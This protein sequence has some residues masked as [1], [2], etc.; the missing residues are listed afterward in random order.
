MAAPTCACRELGRFEPS[1]RRWLSG[2]A[3]TVESSEQGATRHVS[4]SYFLYP[5]QRDSWSIEEELYISDRKVTWSS[6]SRPVKNFSFEAPVLQAVWC[7]FQGGRMEDEMMDRQSNTLDQLP[8]NVYLCVL[9]KNELAVHSSDGEEYT[10]SLPFHAT[11]MWETSA[12][13]LLI[14]AE[15]ENANGPR[16]F[17]LLHPLAE[18]KPVGILQDGKLDILRLSSSKVP[19]LATMV[20]KVF[21]CEQVF[22][23]DEAF[24]PVLMTF[25][26][27]S[28][29]RVIWAVSRLP[30]KQWTPATT[31]LACSSSGGISYEEGD[32][33]AMVY[34]HQFGWTACGSIGLGAEIRKDWRPSHCEVVV[35]PVWRAAGSVESKT[36]IIYSQSND[37]MFL[38]LLQPDDR[39]AVYSVTFRDE[40]AQDFK[41]S[42]HNPSG[43]KPPDHNPRNLKLSDH[44]LQFKSRLAESKFVPKKIINSVAQVTS[45]EAMWGISISDSTSVEKAALALVISNQNELILYQ[46]L[47]PL[48][49]LRLRA[50]SSKYTRLSN[51]VCGRVNV[52]T[53]DGQCFRF[54]VPYASCSLSRSVLV[55]IRNNMSD[56]FYLY[57]RRCMLALEWGVVDGESCRDGPGGEWGYLAGVLQALIE[58][59]KI[60]RHFDA[61]DDFD[62]MFPTNSM[63]TSSSWEL[64]LQSEFHLQQHKGGSLP[65]LLA[66]SCPGASKPS[67]STCCVSDVLLSRWREAKLQV[68]PDALTA[69]LRKLLLALHLLY[70]DVKLNVLMHGQLVKLGRLLLFLSCSLGA[71]SYCDY[72]IRHHPELNSLVGEKALSQLLMAKTD[73][74]ADKIP[75]ICR[76]VCDQLDGY[77]PSPEE[78]VD[79][80]SRVLPMTSKVCKLFACLTGD[81]EQPAADGHRGISEFDQV[82]MQSHDRLSPVPHLLTSAELMRQASGISLREPKHSRQVSH[83]ESVRS[84]R[85]AQTPHGLIQV[86]ELDERRRMAMCESVVEKMIELGMS[87]EDIDCLPLAFA[88]PL[89]ECL[90]ACRANPPKGWG[91]E[92]CR[93][94]SRADLASP[95]A[96][97]AIKVTGVETYDVFKGDLI[98]EM[99]RARQS[100]QAGGGGGGEEF[101]ATDKSNVDGT[102]MDGEFARLRFGKDRRL[103]EVRRCLSAVNPVRIQISSTEVTDHDIHSTNQNKLQLIARRTLALSVGRGMFTLGTATPL[104]TEALPIPP[105]QLSGRL[106]SND[107]LIKLDVSLLPADHAAWPEFHNGVAAALRLSL[108]Q[109]AISRT[110]I[111]YNKPEVA[112]FSHAGVLMGLGLQGHLKALAKPDLYNY[113]CQDHEATQIGIMLGMAAS[114]RSTMDEAVFRMLYVHIPSL[115]PANYPDLEVASPVQTAAI[116]GLGLLYMGS[117]HRRICEVLLAEIGRR[118]TNDKLQD[119]EGYALAA[120]LALG[121]VTLGQGNSAAGLADLQLENMLRKYISGGRAADASQAVSNGSDPSLCCRIK[122]GEN[123]NLDVTSPGA[124]LA[125]GLMFLQTNSRTVAARLEIPSTNFMLQEVRPDLILL[126]ILARNLVLWDKISPSSS[127]FESQIPDIVKGAYPELDDMEQG[128]EKDGR[129]GKHTWVNDVETLRH[130]H[131]NIV[132]G[133]C[134]SLGLR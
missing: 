109:T 1:G 127:F 28:R 22:S 41:L 45:I 17:S 128:A 63:Q 87:K 85:A 78:F 93:L 23:S 26:E 54:Q 62:T 125:L 70:E 98:G 108:G 100:Q 82:R 46:A 104:P 106:Q 96:P 99:K 81:V 72:Y 64:L 92:A 68:S 20:E 126:R 3:T 111:V 86:G 95:V 119:R 133:C 103:V 30:D 88:L 79:P 129:A 110:W 134:L 19:C 69:E 105:L 6:G 15:N 50:P 115:H 52:E 131:A 35:K 9:M 40:T 83:P 4:E 32:A 27:T 58:Q 118:A 48:C 5:S 42:D 49:K 73:G 21:D 124:T 59:L 71:K 14:E 44:T 107:A 8:E 38:G 121:L 77:F 101:A 25:D 97:R 7:S 10:V 114:K 75:D 112:N 13:Y 57:S 117:K 31:H 90:W 47:N 34:S 18:P 67:R 24:L 33:V 120:G 29:E 65:R 12:S 2:S 16:I 53:E 43:F 74:L 132:A 89:R 80:S 102:R 116:M 94:V 39:M 36:A 76:W 91:M 122:E 56:D 55:Q 66:D 130:V 84:S 113:L 61:S 123:V 11:R 37:D 51:S 60:P